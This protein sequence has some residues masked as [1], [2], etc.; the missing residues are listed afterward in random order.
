MPP[1][2]S[3]ALLKVL[4]E[5]IHHTYI[6]THYVSLVWYWPCV[7]QFGRLH[8]EHATRKIIPPK[9]KSGLRNQGILAA[10]F[11]HDTMRL[12]DVKTFCVTSSYL[13]MQYVMWFH[14]AGIILLHVCSQANSCACCIYLWPWKPLHSSHCFILLNKKKHQSSVLH[15]AQSE[16]SLP[17]SQEPDTALSWPSS[18]QTTS[19]P[20]FL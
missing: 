4:S 14:L 11:S 10:T 18:A 20:L 19:S 9:I 16:G 2:F 3:D 5:I 17:W 13:F 7:I 8:L 6:V 15:P 1:L 12:D